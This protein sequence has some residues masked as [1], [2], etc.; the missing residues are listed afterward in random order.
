MSRPSLDRHVFIPAPVPTSAEDDPDSAPPRPSNALVEFY[1]RNE[2]LFIIAASQF[3]FSLMNLCVK[4]LTVL[5]KPVPTFELVAV[6][7]T[8]TYICCQVYMFA[9]GVADPILGPK[10]IRMWLVI[11]GVVGFFGLSGL[12]YSLQYMSLSDATVLTFLSPTVT[13]ALGYLFLGEAVSWR[14]AAAGVTS[15]L[16][17]ILIA[18]PTFLFGGGGHTDV[19]AGEGGPVVTEA[20]RM[21]AVGVALIGVF[22]AAGAYI[23]VRV[24]GKRAHPMHTISYFSLWCVIVATIGMPVAHTEWVL[25][26]RWT[27]LGMLLLIGLFGFLAQLLLTLGL[28]RETASRGTLALYVQI[29]FSLVFERL[30]FG[31]TP[32][33]LSVI[34]TCII[35]ASAIYVA[36]NK[37]DTK[38]SA[39][40]NSEST[41][42]W[43]LESAAEEGR[44]LLDGDERKDEMEADENV[45]KP[46]QQHN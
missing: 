30:A 28:Q 10:G 26:T 3:F 44:G 25:P 32:G 31:A 16:G 21:A 33:V 22:G 29:V 34:G 5:E 2:G 42:M 4:V 8:I 41:A 39:P 20:Q 18:K 35:M 1:K 40:A 24:I 45:K 38:S 9:S 14:Q 11:R 23:S 7:M 19:G 37:P 17:V 36:L 43:N 12:Y 13:A 46:E 15:L 6:R 27:W